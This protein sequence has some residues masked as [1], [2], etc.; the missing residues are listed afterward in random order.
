MPI[1]LP[2]FQRQMYSTNCASTTPSGSS[3]EYEIIWRPEARDDLLAIYDWVAMQADPATALGYT[4]RIEAFV[5]RLGNFPHRGT[6]R[7]D[8]AP[9]LRTLVFERRI[10]IGY[11]VTAGEVSILRL[12]H[13]ARNFSSAFEALD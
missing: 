10:K 8:I 13:S 4:S 5:Q 1:R 7:F 3:V 11:R 9:G 6:A 12:I 2:A